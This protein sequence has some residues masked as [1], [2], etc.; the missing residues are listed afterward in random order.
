MK[1]N[2]QI[3]AGN[4]RYVASDLIYSG[5]N[6][7]IYFGKDSLLQRPVAIKI[8]TKE[9]PLTIPDEALIL[10]KTGFHPNIVNF[11][12][13]QYLDNEKT[14]AMILEYLQPKKVF[15][16]VSLDKIIKETIN[17]NE[18]L[19]VHVCLDFAAQICQ[20]LV[21]VHSY[22]IVHQDLKPAN[23]MV[24]KDELTG[25]LK[26][27]LIDF[28][29]AFSIGQQRKFARWGGTIRYAAPE[30]VKKDVSLIDF[31]TDIFSLG[32]ILYE[33]L[34]LKLPYRFGGES[35]RDSKVP[36]PIHLHSI[37]KNVSKQLSSLVQK[38]L[39]VELTKRYPG[40]SQLLNEIRK[41]QFTQISQSWVTNFLKSVK[42]E[43]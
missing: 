16:W 40:A 17:K 42:E 18:S 34:G 30:Q 43:S 29:I 15:G 35:F 11:F 12:D 7:H 38:C 24:R 36:S 1:K 4:R 31:R 10:S 28:S 20:A 5:V 23:I 13:L 6:S 22:G 21:H 39:E 3:S 19:P 14:P 2:I 32:V 26:F 27:K 41:I 8:F 25:E 37:N 9:K 33:L